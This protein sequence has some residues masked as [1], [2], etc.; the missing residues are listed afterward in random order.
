MSNSL[1]SVAIRQ[2]PSHGF[3]AMNQAQQPEFPV[4]DGGRSP[5]RSPPSTVPS[6]KHTHVG[7]V[8]PLGSA[9]PAEAALQPA[10][11]N[12]AADAHVDTPGSA[13]AGGGG[14]GGS[15]ARARVRS[16]SRWKADERC[17]RLG[18][19]LEREQLMVDEEELNDIYEDIKEVR[20]WVQC[21]SVAIVVRSMTGLQ[22]CAQLCGFNMLTNMACTHQC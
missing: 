15:T 9:E 10:P 13:A 3:C 21:A 14:G 8:A 19:I 6:S 17:L 12:A 22:F 4:V 20:P 2:S 5:P 16:G 7:S 11:A 18:N 1:C